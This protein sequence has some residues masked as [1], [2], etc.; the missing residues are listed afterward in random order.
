VYSG[1][2]G[3]TP[4][5]DQLAAACDLLILECANDTGQVTQFH[6]TP[7]ECGRI[8]SRAG[9]KQLVLTHYGSLTRKTALRT[10]TERHFRGTLEFRE[11]K[12]HICMS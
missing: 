8:A 11:E 2:T 3:A 12:K 10:A 4:A 5:L 7:E 6:L 1:D 9:A